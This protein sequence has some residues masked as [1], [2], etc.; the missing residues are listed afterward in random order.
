MK[1]VK[2]KLIYILLLIFISAGLANAKGKKVQSINF[3][4][5]EIEGV[6]RNPD[7]NYLVQKRGVKFLPLFKVKKKFK[8]S[9]LESVDYL[10]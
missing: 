10:R 5:S 2:S 6:S 4:A 1:K 7:G 9:I 8:K 3:D